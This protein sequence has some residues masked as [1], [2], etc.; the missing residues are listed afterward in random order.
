M[1][2]ALAELLMSPDPV[3]RAQGRELAL[4]LPDETAA[5]L[6]E[7]L[8]VTDGW[9]D[10]PDP[11][12]AVLV[13]LLL[14]LPGLDDLRRAV[15]GLH[16]AGPGVQAL[17]PQLV[18]AMPHL[19][20][21][22]LSFSDVT[23]LRPLAALPRLRDLRLDNSDLKELSGLSRLSLRALSLRWCDLSSTSLLSTQPALETLRIGQRSAQPTEIDLSGFPQLRTVDLQRLTPSALPP[24]LHTLLARD[25]DGAKLPEET[26]SLPLRVLGLSTLRPRSA[27]P[28]TLRSLRLWATQPEPLPGWPLTR[29]HFAPHLESLPLNDPTFRWLQRTYHDPG[30]G[31]MEQRLLE[32]LQQRTAPLVLDFEPVG[33]D[34]PAHL[35]ASPMLVR[36]A[37]PPKMSALPDATLARSARHWHAHGHRWQLQQAQAGSYHRIKMIK[38]ARAWLDLS[39]K[40]AKLLDDHSLKSGYACLTG[41]EARALQ[42]LG[43]YAGRWMVR[44]P[45]A[46]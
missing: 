44:R 17:L 10:S 8:T 7:H 40:Q 46:P 29:C 26:W 12:A 34:W 30:E 9:L 24:G 41:S 42:A 36:M 32:A 2:E 39:L 16:V 20:A 22:D 38:G 14:E 27:S 19:E 3:L 15:T 25:A 18:A 11:P 4:S 28:P 43:L 5:A 33:L 23:D 1:R 35:L 31:R 45:W 21:L 13:S 37:L 6:Q